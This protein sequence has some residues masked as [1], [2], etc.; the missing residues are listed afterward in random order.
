MNHSW[1]RSQAGLCCL[2]SRDFMG[3]EKKELCTQ[4]KTPHL[5]KQES[6]SGQAE[7]G[8][9]ERGGGGLCAARHGVLRSEFSA[10]SPPLQGNGKSVT[11]GLRGTA[12]HLLDLLSESLGAFKQREVLCGVIEIK[13]AV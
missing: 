4:E 8:G 3:F 12:R 10:A 1:L 6:L 2:S 5:L 11:H 7:R 13:P 9:E